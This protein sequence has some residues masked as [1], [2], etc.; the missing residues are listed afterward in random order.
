MRRQKMEEYLQIS[1]HN[2]RRAWEIIR[3][4]K[5]REI[6]E[7]HGAE[8]N[9]IGSLAMGLM[10]KHRDIDFHIYTNKL[11]IASSFAA[12]AELA[13]QPGIRKVDYTNML[14]DVDKC[15]EWHAWYEDDDQRVWQFDMMHILRGSRYDGYFEK[16]AKA[17][18][19][20]VTEEQKDAIL[21]LKFATPEGEKIMGIE[22]YQ[23]VIRDGIR[24]YPSLQK[25]RKERPADR[26]IEWMPE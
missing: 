5:I 23:A 8:I 1:E 19:N 14:D 15:L 12:M 2:Q 11:T 18:K 13:V 3:K 20:K 25:W 6:W 24:D 7:A 9:L 4:L 10:N 22:Y 17:I 16:M 26:I 21:K